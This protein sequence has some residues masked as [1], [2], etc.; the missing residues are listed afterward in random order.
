M[1]N[2]SAPY[3]CTYVESKFVN[4]SLG[5]WRPDEEPYIKFYESDTRRRLAKCAFCRGP[6]QTVVSEKWR[7]EINRDSVFTKLEVRLCRIC[8]WWLL[9]GTAPMIGPEGGMLDQK[10]LIGL[11]KRY[12]ISAFDAPLEELRRFLEKH[13]ENLAHVNPTRFEMLLRDCIEDAYAPCKV[14]HVGGTGDGGIDLKM[15]TLDEE[16]YLIQV[17]RRSDLTKREGVRVVRELNGVLFRENRA[18]GIIVTTAKGFTKAA[19]K[20]RQVKTPTEQRYEMQ[21]LSYSDILNM[22]NSRRVAAPNPWDK[23]LEQARRYYSNDG[24]FT[25]SDKL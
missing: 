22:L 23:D 10:Q 15:V 5:H 14:F 3:L 9:T 7:G 12:K 4:S 13:P 1:S 19:E 16:E 21:L 24:Q 20:E 8:G 2:S 11:A 6:M 17:K 18:K 25:M